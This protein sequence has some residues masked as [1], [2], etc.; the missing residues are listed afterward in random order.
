M[1]ANNRKLLNECYGSND[2]NTIDVVTGSNYIHLGVT[3]TIV[4]TKLLLALYLWMQR[5]GMCIMDTT[6]INCD[7][8]GVYLHTL[9]MVGEY[10]QCDM[11]GI[12]LQILSYGRRKHTDT[13]TC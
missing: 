8:T 4:N 3:D 11:L 1:T 5:C 12:Y 6:N 2:T 7:R 10:S 9:C 13:L